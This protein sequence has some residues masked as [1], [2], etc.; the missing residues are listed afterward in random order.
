MKVTKQPEKTKEQF[1][2]SILTD[3]YRGS[4]LIKHISLKDFF[5]WIMPSCLNDC[6]KNQL[7]C[8]FFN[9]H[10]EDKLPAKEGY[11]ESIRYDIAS[12]RRDV[13]ST[14]FKCGRDEGN[15]FMDIGSCNGEKVAIALTLRCG[16][17][18]FDRAIGVEVSKKSHNIA[19][20]IFKGFEDKAELLNIDAFDIT[21]ERFKELNPNLIYMYHPIREENKMIKLARHVI[22]NM[23][24]DCTL[25]E[26]LPSYINRFLKEECDVIERESYSY[27]AQRSESIKTYFAPTAQRVGGSAARIKNYDYK[28]V[29]VHG[30]QVFS[31]VINEIR[32]FFTLK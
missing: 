18:T 26:V 25:L 3:S 24:Q 13:D 32:S 28:G 27:E 11:Y 22:S 6:Y 19:K 14:Y 8:E 17:F 1:Y 10:G 2:F 21:K 16:C 23:P 30:K 5:K 7:L 4:D 15:I 9:E 29:S 12:F 20:K 31:C